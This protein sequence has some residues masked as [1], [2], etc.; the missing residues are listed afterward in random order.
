MIFLWLFMGVIAFM[1]VVYQLVLVDIRRNPKKKEWPYNS[2]LYYTVR[3]LEKERPK[4]G[5]KE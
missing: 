4:W 5:R 3:E 2:Q 1:F